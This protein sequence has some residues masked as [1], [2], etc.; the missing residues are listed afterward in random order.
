MYVTVTKQVSLQILLCTDAVVHFS[1]QEKKNTLNSIVLTHTNLLLKWAGDLNSVELQFNE[2]W[3]FCIGEIHML[4]YSLSF[5]SFQG[6]L[7]FKRASF[8]TLAS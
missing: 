5:I 1:R 2:S 7:I 3:F 8:L 6:S 4:S